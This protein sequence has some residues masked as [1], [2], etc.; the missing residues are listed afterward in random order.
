[1]SFYNGH[2]LHERKMTMDTTSTTPT[3]G[4][5]ILEE[6]TSEQKNTPQFKTKHEKLFYELYNEPAVNVEE[7]R[8]LALWHFYENMFN[9]KFEAGSFYELHDSELDP[10]RLIIWPEHVTQKQL[11]GFLDYVKDYVYDDYGRIKACIDE[12]EKALDATICPRCGRDDGEH[13]KVCKLNFLTDDQV[14]A[15]INACGEHLQINF[16]DGIPF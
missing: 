5:F 2:K 13:D 10:I 1:M 11:L 12:K 9:G 15:V 16:D 4:G 7:G 6:P 3:P 8:V 14:K